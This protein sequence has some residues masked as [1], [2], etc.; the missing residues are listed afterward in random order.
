MGPAALGAGAG[1][2]TLVARAKLGVT[3][4]T[5]L[6]GVLGKASLALVALGAAATG[7]ELLGNALAKN[8]FGDFSKRVEENIAS[9]QRF[10]DLQQSLVS[11]HSQTRDDQLKSA[12]ASGEPID[13]EQV[14]KAANRPVTKQSQ[15]PL[16]L[17]E[18]N[19]R[20]AVF[21]QIIA[22]ANTSQAQVAKL[23]N[24]IR[25]LDTQSAGTLGTIAKLFS[26]FDTGGTAKEIEN[27]RNEILRLASSAEISNAD[28]DKLEKRSQALQKL[29][30]ATPA[31]KLGY[32]PEAQ[33]TAGAVQRLRQ[34]QAL[35]KQNP[36]LDQ[37]KQGLAEINA[38]FS[39]LPI[40]SFSELQRA[41]GGGAESS[42]AIAGNLER[43]AAAA[44]Q[45]AQAQAGGGG[46]G[47]EELWRG[48]K[49]RYFAGG[50]PVGPDRVPAWLSRGESVLNAGATSKFYSQISA[51]NAGHSPTAATPVGD[52]TV[53]MGGVT[54]NEAGSA[55]QTADA[56]VNTIRRAQRR[57]TSRPF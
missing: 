38:A 14:S 34:I 6:Y 49:P 4:G 43:A 37:A 1:L 36:G 33:S 12:I 44:R 29:S 9:L 23:Q 53:N 18:A 7:G 51:M 42:A 41:L 35:Q 5:A 45:A 54:I 21:E 50:G 46:A 28:L 10:K 40:A 52:T 20:A 25:S 16:A 17:K 48:G 19:D 13:L 31:T 56:V 8:L 22:S 24:E 47:G 27:I 2:A 30:E 39:S 26:G 15:V 11:Q 57:G 55:A 32:A 3:E